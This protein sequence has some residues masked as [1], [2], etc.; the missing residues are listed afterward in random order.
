V[1]LDQGFSQELP[2]PDAS[3]DR[4]FSSFMFH[5]LDLDTKA[6]T[7]RE[8][9]RVL[10]PGG[11]LHLLDFGGHSHGWLARLFHASHELEDNA[12]DRILALMREAGLANPEDVAHRAIILGGITS[13]RAAA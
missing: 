11:S 6:A 5:H 8:T 1:Q 13:Y 7:L 2:Y 3:F 4:A 9:R 10:R 12:E